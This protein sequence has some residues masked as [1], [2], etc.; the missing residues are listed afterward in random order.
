MVGPNYKRP[1]APQTPAFKEAPPEGWKEAQPNDGAIRGKWWEIYNDPQLNALEEQVSISNQNV[2]AAEANFR[3][4]RYA[5]GVARPPCIRPFP[6]GLPCD[7]RELGRIRHGGNFHPTSPRIIRPT[8][9]RRA[10]VWTADIWGSVRRSVRQ[11]DYSPGRLRLAGECPALV[12][13]GI[14]ARTTSICMAPMATSTC[15]QRT[16]KSYEDYLNLTQ[17]RYKAG[18][19]SGRRCGTGADSVGHYP[20]PVD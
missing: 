6:L 13:I 7:S 11:P 8:A 20:G 3:A 17:D 18:V 15:S 19:A 9:C 10:P 4:A 14:G 16:V 5:V 12:P 1:A 2:L